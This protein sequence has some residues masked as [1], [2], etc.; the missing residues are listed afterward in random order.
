MY[1]ISSTL[2]RRFAGGKIDCRGYGRSTG[3][4]IRSGGSRMSIE[5]RRDHRNRTE[6]AEPNPIAETSNTLN[7]TQTNRK[8]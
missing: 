8:K 4:R 1:W 5:M 7:K 3:D 6:K 2:R